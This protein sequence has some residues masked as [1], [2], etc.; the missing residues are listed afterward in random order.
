MD[1]RC[2]VCQITFECEDENFTGDLNCPQCEAI[3]RKVEPMPS[4]PPQLVPPGQAVQQAGLVPPGQAP[5]QAGLVPPGQAPQGDIAP[6]AGGSSL[7]LRKP[8]E[9][10]NNAA[11]P[12]PPPVGTPQQGGFSVFQNQ[13]NQQPQHEGSCRK[14]GARLAPEAVL[15]I[16][17]GTKVE[18]G[19]LRG[20]DPGTISLHYGPQLETGA[21]IVGI[22]SRLMMGLIIAYTLLFGYGIFKGGG[23]G[24][25]MLIIFA[26]TIGYLYS[27]MIRLTVQIGNCAQWMDSQPKHSMTFS[28][29]YSSA[30]VLIFIGTGLFLV[31]I[32]LM[33]ALIFGRGPDACQRPTKVVRGKADL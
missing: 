24:I 21:I 33:M 12:P 32:A 8:Q 11:P 30:K 9:Q 13:Q 16:Q 25:I 1:F 31:P 27:Y 4:Q 20:K 10:T 26:P 3:L 15:C 14:C 28:S 2:D 19:S 5:Q 6:P 7:S 18:G 22:F 23:F 17:C 29:M